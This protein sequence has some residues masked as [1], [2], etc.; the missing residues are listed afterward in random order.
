MGYAHQQS[1]YL[2][3]VTMKGIKI[4]ER[5]SEKRKNLA[6]EAMNQ[7]K[8]TDIEKLWLEDRWWA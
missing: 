8:E 6:H 1:R 2:K 5:L 4:C 7:N 3:Y